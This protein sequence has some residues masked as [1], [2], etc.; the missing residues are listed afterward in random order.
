MSDRRPIQGL[1]EI[2]LRVADLDS[3]QDFYQRVIGLELMRRFPGSAFFRIAPGVAGHTQ[4]LALFDRNDEPSYRG[5][6]A[7]TTTVD[8]LAFEIAL[9]EYE[10]ELARLRALGLNVTTT[11]HA[12]V[13]WR[14]LYV[15][16]P[17][18]NRVELVCFDP[19]V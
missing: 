13:H 18:G 5:L 6:D 19:S 11:T 2:A 14:S 10:P 8:H 15:D 16:D 12:W 7:A 17:E 3:M 4:V 1:G 9:D